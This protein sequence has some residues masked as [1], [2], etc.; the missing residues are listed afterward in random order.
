VAHRTAAASGV[1]RNA[2]LS[3]CD[4]VLKAIVDVLDVGC[5][6]GLDALALP[7]PTQ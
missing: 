7:I 4:G 6:T 3:A 5:G 1:H 2:S